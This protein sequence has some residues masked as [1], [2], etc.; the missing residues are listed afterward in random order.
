[1]HR[2]LLHL[3]PRTRARQRT[4]RDAREHTDAGRLVDWNG[5]LDGATTALRN[6][7]FAA[8]DEKEDGRGQNDGGRK[9][10]SETFLGLLVAL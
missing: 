3:L 2:R 5:T 4:R 10:R 9:I 8:A 1:M 7:I 6:F